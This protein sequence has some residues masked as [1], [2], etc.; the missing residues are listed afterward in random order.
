MLESKAALVFLGVQPT[1]KSLAM[2]FQKFQWK[3]PVDSI[4][5]KKL[6]TKLLVK[7]CFHWKKPDALSGF[8][9]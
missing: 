9:G 6:V 8:K 3:T 5:F 1:N 4:F 7:G 2:K